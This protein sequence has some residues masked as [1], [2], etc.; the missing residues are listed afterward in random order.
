MKQMVSALAIAKTADGP[1]KRS[2][3]SAV[4]LREWS[5]EVAVRLIMRQHVDGQQLY[6]AT[7]EQVDMM[8]GLFDDPR[9]QKTLP[10]V[11]HAL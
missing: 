9:W 1:R 7:I 4:E 6:A 2:G 5:T 11:C 3:V 10:K 8:V